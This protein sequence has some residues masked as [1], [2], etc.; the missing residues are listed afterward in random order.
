MPVLVAAAEANEAIVGQ[1]LTARDWIVAGAI[2]VTGLVLARIVRGLVARAAGGVEDD[3]PAAAEAVG[4]SVGMAL[5]AVSLLYALGVLGVRLGPLVGA[6]GIGG[7]ALAFAGQTILANFLA[8]IILQLRHPFRRGDQVSV[9]DCEGTVDDVNFRTVVLR[10][11]DGERVMVPCAQVLA[12]PITNHTTLGRR[13]TTVEVSVAY[14]TDLEQA[15][16]VLREALAATDGVLDRP[17]P[18]V[19]VESF[20]D[21]GINLAVRFWHPPD[22]ATL[23]RTRS[24]VAVAV[25]RALDEDGIR[26]P[27]PQRVVRF[28][29][30]VAGGSA[31]D[32]MEESR[33]GD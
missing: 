29:D 26:I 18:E 30:D 24:Q 23:W 25:K 19:W 33:P 2:V 17:A 9:A 10:T 12:T 20:A 11:F 7:L 21:S 32:R 4:R 27:F 31:R 3:E 13:R 1:P 5:A 28:A 15:L 22:I 8:S 14:D 16:A 6:L